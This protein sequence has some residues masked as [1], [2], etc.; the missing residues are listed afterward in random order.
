[1]DERL[2]TYRKNRERFGRLVLGSVV[3][4]KPAELRVKLIASDASSHVFVFK[5]EDRPPRKLLSVGMLE[6]VRHGFGHGHG[7]LGGMHP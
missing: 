5:V 6:T 1:M 7:G 2:R 4:S 3:E